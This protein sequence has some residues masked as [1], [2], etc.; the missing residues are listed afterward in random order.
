MTVPGREPTTSLPWVH[1][2]DH[3]PLTHQTTTTAEHVWKTSWPIHNRNKPRSPQDTNER[4][5]S[6]TSRESRRP[7]QASTNNRNILYAYLT[8]T[9]SRKAWMFLAV[10]TTLQTKPPFDTDILRESG[11]KDIYYRKGKK[12]VVQTRQQRDEKDLQLRI[13]VQVPWLGS[14]GEIYIT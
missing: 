12:N 10:L 8:N 6:I 9:S 13:L 2:L 11:H 4:E 5:R 1:D 7:L 14:D 3:S